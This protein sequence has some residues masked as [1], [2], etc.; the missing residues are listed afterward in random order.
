LTNLESNHPLPPPY[1]RRGKPLQQHFFLLY[2]L[3]ELYELDKLD[4]P[5]PAFALL[6]YNYDYIL[7]NTTNY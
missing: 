6:G 4:R 7:N 3:D 2:K 5:T 1:P